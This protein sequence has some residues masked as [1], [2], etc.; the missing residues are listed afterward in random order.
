MTPPS[1]R[2]VSLAHEPADPGA[3]PLQPKDERARVLRRRAQVR[4]RGDL[5]ARLR[6]RR[7]I[8][9]PRAELAARLRRDRGHGAPEQSVA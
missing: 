2:H 3:A 8:G 9:R 7:Q 4:R 1:P 6:P 5:G